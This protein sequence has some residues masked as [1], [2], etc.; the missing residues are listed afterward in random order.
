M[1][2]LLYCL[3]Y[4]A[5]LAQAGALTP[6][7]LLAQ[8]PRCTH[9]CIADALAGL[10]GDLS[11]VASYVCENTTLQSELSTCTQTSCL[12]ADQVNAAKL[13]TE[14][15][16]AFP[17]ASRS[18]DVN[19]AI[20]VGCA[21]VFPTI[22]LRLYT[23]VTCTG[24]LWADDYA[25]ILAAVLLASLAII[26]LCS[27]HLGLGMHYWTIPTGH[28]ILILK[29]F[30]A[31]SIIYTLLLIT[32]KISILLLY[33]R[34]FPVQ[35]FLWVIKGLGAFLGCHGVLYVLLIAMQCL[36]VYTI[37]DR[38]VTDRKCIDVTAVAYSS[39]ALSILEDVAILLLPIPQ[40]WQLK[41]DRRR[42]LGL[43]A[44]FSIGSFACFTSMIRMKFVVQYNATFDATW[45]NVD[46]IVWSA[47]EQF[48]AMFC[49]SL[50]ALRLLFI[51]AHRRA[52]AEIRQRYD[53]MPSRALPSK[54]SIP[55][56]SPSRGIW[57][58]QAADTQANSACTGNQIGQGEDGIRV[59]TVVQVSQEPG[60][61]LDDSTQNHDEDVEVT[62]RT[63]IVTRR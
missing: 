8:T 18:H 43:I 6:A 30:Y 4:F 27:A 21:L 24:R 61:W 25:T 45:N 42:Q 36:P 60:T 1:Q 5:W 2:P 14:L 13:E 17:K 56:Q 40:V 47:I 29:L 23:R 26:D 32:S 49:G 51:R 41:I 11:N 9:R 12:Y 53:N 34:L 7:E 59:T 54:N 57:N 46:I 22:A 16:A 3:P 15:C 52:S 37:W 38:Y 63:R 50:P 35:T 33:A 19:R 31:E 39:G 48:T 28:G 10:N 58:N 44:I 20:I 62:N 55:T